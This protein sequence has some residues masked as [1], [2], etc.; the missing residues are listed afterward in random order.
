MLNIIEKYCTRWH[1]KK[2]KLWVVY[3]DDVISVTDKTNI[4]LDIVNWVLNW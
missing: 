3:T 2:K 1:I 4:V